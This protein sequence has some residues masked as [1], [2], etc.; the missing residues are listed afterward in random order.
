MLQER[1]S[2][3][4][5]PKAPAVWQ[6]LRY[7]HEPLSYLE[8]CARQYGD[9]FL[10]R[11]AGYGKLV[12][13]ADPEAVRDVFRGDPH[14]LHSGEGNEFMSG[15]VGPNSVLVLDDQPHARQRRILLPPLKGE[16]MRSFFDAMQSATLEAVKGW[17]PDRPVRMVEPMQWITLRVILQA[18][19]G[20]APGPRL[21]GLEDKVGRMLALGRSRY[22]LALL[23]LVPQRLLRNSRWVPYF[24]Q[25]RALDEALFALIAERRREPA[26]ARGE[27]VLADLL[28]ASHEGGEPI[29]DAEIRDAV[30]T[31]LIAGHDTTAL[32]LAWAL[33]QI[34]PREDVVRPLTDELH[35]V[36]G[37]ELP[38]AEHLSRLEYLDAAV[39]ES[40]RVR[41]I[42]P[43]VVR[44]TKQPFVAG[45]REYPAGVMLAPCNHLVHRRLDLYPDP[46]RFRPERFLER[47]YAG[48]EWFPFGGGNRT[49]LGMAFALYEMKV[50]LATLFRTV[51]LARPPGSRS[52]PVRRGISL[53]P[54][55]G[56][57]VVV[58]ARL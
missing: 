43:F 31:L 55:D 44:L 34:V 30:V 50:V 49:C 51:C 53:A 4:P 42:L 10:V 16:R 35:R 33:E 23:P 41:T 15:T 25:M 24:R 52:A 48:H 56:A 14:V 40:L 26:A 27:N 58:T 45:G 9:R 20:L 19:L 3:P 13:L 22:G 36:C 37:G 17:P 8:S 57:R 11:L 38:R 29:S 39:R 5:G 47:K 46:G 32:A 6:L 21:T 18:V 7:T 2:L 1:V 54:D 28:A 12:M